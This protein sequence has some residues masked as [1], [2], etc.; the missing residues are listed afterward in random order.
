MELSN[1]GA[2]CIRD[3][4]DRTQRNAEIESFHNLQNA[5]DRVGFMF[6]FE[7][8]VAL[9]RWQIPSWWSRQS[10]WISPSK[11]K[12]QSKARLHSLSHQERWRFR[13]D[14]FEPDYASTICR[15]RLPGEH[16]KPQVVISVNF[17]L[18]MGII[19]EIFTVGRA[20]DSQEARGLA[21]C[22]FTS[23]EAMLTPR[24]FWAQILLGDNDYQV[25]TFSRR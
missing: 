4:C 20:F 17:T 22:A 13:P 10:I 7:D 1:G 5:V 24:Q 15:Q 14:G 2:M 25:N 19:T 6:F 11:G 16:V 21:A 8:K 23:G 9:N 18:I 12:K 3:N